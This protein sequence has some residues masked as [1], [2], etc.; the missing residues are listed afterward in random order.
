MTRIVWQFSFVLYT[1]NDDWTFSKKC[2]FCSRKLFVLRNDHKKSWKLSKV[3]FWLKPNMQNMQNLNA[4]D[5]LYIFIKDLMNGLKL[6]KMSKNWSLKENGS[7]YD[8]KRVFWNNIFDKI[9]KL[10]CLLLPLNLFTSIPRAP[11][12]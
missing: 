4:T 8:Q 10:W 3:K 11:C 1:S 2:S 6:Q 12:S 5:L 7:S 9:F